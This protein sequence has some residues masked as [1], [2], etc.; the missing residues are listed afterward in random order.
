M[1]INK[2]IPNIICWIRICLIPFVLLFLLDSPMVESISV[3]S[4]ILISGIIFI[5]A[6]LSDIADGKIARKYNLVSDFG[7]F[8]DP[9]AD[10]MLVLG[11]LAAFI[12]CGLS[13][14]VPFLLILAREF[15]ITGIRLTAASKG[16]VIAANI[17]GKIK[18]VVQG[19]V[20]SGM[21]VYMYV[22]SLINPTVSYADFAGVTNICI[23]LIAVVTVGS[24]IPYIKNNGKYLRG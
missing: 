5:V 18:T 3:S 12:E 6:M 15:L 14:S 2:N 13:S 24:V 8:L 7:K 23:W 17:W 1:K 21:F 4:R 19:V 11:V 10:K 16:E 20:M 9:I 22:F